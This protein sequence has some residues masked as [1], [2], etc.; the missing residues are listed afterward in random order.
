[1]ECW[2]YCT[3]ATILA[4]HRQYRLFIMLK[5]VCFLCFSAITCVYNPYNLLLL[6]E[7]ENKVSL[8][9]NTLRATALCFF[10]NTLPPIPFCSFLGPMNTTSEVL[11]ILQLLFFDFLY[12]VCP[13]IFFKAFFLV[14]VYR[15]AHLVLSTLF[16]LNIPSSPYSCI[17]SIVL[18]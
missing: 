12:V 17:S 1:M 8:S 3:Y 2:V 18:L 11:D 5:K 14:I 10:H 15:C 6:S 16:S 4:T 13:E 9:T 7:T